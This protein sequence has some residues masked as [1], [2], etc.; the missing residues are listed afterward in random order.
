L[1]ERGGEG[2]DLVQWRCIWGATNETWPVQHKGADNQNGGE[3]RKKVQTR[4]ERGARKYVQGKG[5]RS[6][7]ANEY[8]LEGAGPFPVMLVVSGVP[9]A[10][11]E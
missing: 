10:A 2:N 8:V 3:R 1:R 9:N 6:A 4:E 7:G 11:Q 5:R